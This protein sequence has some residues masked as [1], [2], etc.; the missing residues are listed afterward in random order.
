MAGYNRAEA[1]DLSLFEE[2]IVKQKIEPIGIKKAPPQ[3]NNKKAATKAAAAKNRTTAAYAKS[4]KG[5]FKASAF[6]IVC[7]F[8]LAVILLSR[9]Q[10]DELT[11]EIVKLENELKIVQ[12]ETVRLNTALSSLISMDK[13]ESYAEERLGM[14]K[15]ENHQITYIDMSKGDM[16]VL[17]GQKSAIKENLTA[18]LKELFAYPPQ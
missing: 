10:S 4:L 5:A 14:V 3:D 13:V 2:Q 6:A 9:A 18:R 15:A 1:Y 17:S 8:S 11:R 7:L 16:I 12:S